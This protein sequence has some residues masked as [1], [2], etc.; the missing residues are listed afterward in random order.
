MITFYAPNDPYGPFSNFSQHL[1]A[2]Y[3][4]TWLTSEHPFQA[5]K[6]WPHR[7]DLVDSVH[8]AATPGRAARIG[9]NRANPLRTDWD[10]LPGADIQYGVDRTQPRPSPYPPLIVDDGVYRPGVEAEAIFRRGKDVFMYEIVLA[11]FRQHPDIKELLLGTGDQP[12]VEDAI[13]DPYWGWGP[14]KVGENKLGRI[15]MLV[16]DTLRSS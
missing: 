4:R 2:I 3:D 7:P 1:V 10:R 14:S 5:M 9:R 8:Q 6:F 12:I 15:L 11:K 16:R 13:A